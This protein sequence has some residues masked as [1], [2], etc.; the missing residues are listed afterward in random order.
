MAWGGLQ[1]TYIFNK[2]Y[3]NDPNHKNYKDR[4]RILDR[5]NAEKKGSQYYS[6]TP[7]GTPCKK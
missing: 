1:G 2:N 7:I 3:P 4:E 5:I 6:A